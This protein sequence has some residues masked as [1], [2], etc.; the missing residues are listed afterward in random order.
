MTA[1]TIDERT[2]HPV[3]A[4]FP[5]LPDD[6]ATYRELVESIRTDGQ[7][8]PIVIDEAG[9]IID[10]RH[11][12]R[13]C[14]E[15]GIEPKLIVRQGT[16]NEIETFAY[17][18]NLHR[19]HLTPEQRA[20]VATLY[21]AK[22]WRVDANDRRAAAVEARERN[23]D[24]TLASGVEGDTTGSE[25]RERVDQAEVIDAP[26]KKGGRAHEEIQQIAKVGQHTARQALAVARE[27]PALAGDVLRGDVKLS[28]AFKKVAPR[29]SAPKAKQPKAEQPIDVQDILRK[30]GEALTS[31]KLSPSD[32][33]HIALFA[34]GMIQRAA[35]Q[36]Q[37][38]DKLG[39]YARVQ[40]ALGFPETVGHLELGPETTKLVIDESKAQEMAVVPQPAVAPRRRG[41]PPKKKNGAADAT[42]KEA[43][44][45]RPR[46]RPRKN[47]LPTP[48]DP[49]RKRG[50]PRKAAA[51]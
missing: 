51:G 1:D 33:E 7:R 13:A 16:P 46:G 4:L 26:K 14:I 5:L 20:M 44:P 35:P 28:E 2:V 22:N 38:I 45:K 25:A 48:S 39:I 19:R 11:R 34:V 21:I 41:R 18:V 15:I 10:G 24:G 37:H 49:P 6:D 40:T 3:C 8:E 29:N 36:L 47:P 42:P 9:A 31:R 43:Q 27:S 12:L 32:S 50:R 30:A 23:A 17:S